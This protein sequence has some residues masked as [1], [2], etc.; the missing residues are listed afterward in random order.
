MENRR[1]PLRKTLNDCDQ[2]LEVQTHQIDGRNLTEGQP[3]HVHKTIYA[4]LHS[5]MSLAL[6]ISIKGT[7]AGSG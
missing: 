7:T 3:Q 6:C 4:C 5:T 2:R 1:F